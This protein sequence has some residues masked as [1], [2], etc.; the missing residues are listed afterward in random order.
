M[1]KAVQLLNIS[2]HFGDV[3]ANKNVDLE[4]EKGEIYGLV[5]E[6]GAGKTTL[7]NILS[8]MI[9]PDAGEILIF[10]KKVHIQGP[11]QALAMGIGMVYQHFMLSPSLTVLENVILGKTPTRFGLIDSKAAE[12]RIQEI[13]QKY[14]LAVDLH[15]KVYELS[16]G[17]MQRVEILKALYRGAEILILDEPTA[18]LTP[19]DTRE[20]F[21]ILQGMKQRGQ[22]IIFITHKLKEVLAITERVTVM[23][24]GVVTGV[25]QTKDTSEQQLAC[26]MVGREVV[27]RIKKSKAH[28]QGEVL[29]V[30]RL[31]AKNDRGL[32][33]LKNVD[34]NLREGEILGI[35]GVEGNGQSELVQVLNGLRRPTTGSISFN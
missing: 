21:K 30:S 12:R 4:I 2:K 3:I 5:G 19:Q 20:L 25:L 18:V 34:F 13:I 26:L 15:K 11:H 7:M 16:V 1:T 10:E 17:E 24:H 6:N 33:A 22:T 27:L 31:S 32:I 35:A 9:Q 23:Q 29:K 14:F 28:I 8:G